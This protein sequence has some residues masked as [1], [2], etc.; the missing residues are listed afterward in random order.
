MCSFGYVSPSKLHV[1]VCM[2]TQVVYLLEVWVSGFAASF[3]SAAN[4]CQSTS[5]SLYLTYDSHHSSVNCLVANL[6]P[7][8]SIPCP[9]VSLRLVCWRASASTVC[10]C[11]SLESR[12]LSLR[13]TRRYCRCTAEFPRMLIRLL[14][15]CNGNVCELRTRVG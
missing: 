3:S 15:S 12:S 4:C 2:A 11:P 14:F 5:H 13:R 6:A 9:A 7:C 8:N 1:L 10:P